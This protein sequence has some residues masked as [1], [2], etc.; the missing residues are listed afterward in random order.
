M[1]AENKALKAFN[2]QLIEEGKQQ[3]P[4]TIPV[5]AFRLLVNILTEMAAGNAVTLIPIYAEHTTQEAADL[6][7]VSRPYLVQLLEEGK[8]SFRKVGSRRR[9][10]AKDLIQ[11]KEEIDNLRLKAVEELTEQ[12]QKLDTG[13]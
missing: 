6:L 3:E 11:Y 12:A 13:Y 5:K 10:L 1:Q 2:I 7:N 8:I 9:V 4:I